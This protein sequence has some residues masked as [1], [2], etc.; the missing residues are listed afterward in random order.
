LT[1]RGFKKKE[2][3]KVG[4]IIHNVLKNPHDNNLKKN[5]RG[6]ISYLAK[7]YDKLNLSHGQKLPD[8]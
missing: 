2:F 6:K 3:E 5:L 7:K 1:T 8:W 4:E